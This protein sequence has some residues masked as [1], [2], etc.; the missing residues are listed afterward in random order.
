MGR[1]SPPFL[2]PH[3]TSEKCHGVV[4]CGML[5]C[6]LH[7]SFTPSDPRDWRLTRFGTLTRACMLHAVHMLP[8]P[9]QMRTI[10]PLKKGLWGP[11]AACSTHDATTLILISLATHACS[12]SN[13]LCT[14]FDFVRVPFEK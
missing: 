13:V 11:T 1:P 2:P 6:G 8:A 10:F 3:A 12:L 5:A 9:S 7:N 4:L 14:N